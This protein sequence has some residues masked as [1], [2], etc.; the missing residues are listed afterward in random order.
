MKMILPEEKDLHYCTCQYKPKFDSFG[1]VDLHDLMIQFQNIAGEHVERLGLGEDFKKEKSFYYI[2]CRM[3]GY[4]LGSLDENET[5]T[6]VT[7]PTQATS[8]QL[9]RYAYILDSKGDPVFY[10]ISLWVLMSQ[11]TRRLISSKVF[12]EKIKEVLPDIDQVEPLTHE[13]LTELNIGDMEFHYFSSYVVDS[14]DIDVNQHMNNTVYMKIAQS[15]CILH[16]IS[17]FEIDFEKECYLNETIA[18]ESYSDNNDYYVVGRKNDGILS[19]IVKFSSK[20]N[21]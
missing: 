1:N 18:L 13:K 3:K 4:F 15:S 9:Y 21:F 5:Y 14:K 17:T 11:E 20:E 8:L 10:L 6:F 16:P 12:R 2:L 19:F 7:Y